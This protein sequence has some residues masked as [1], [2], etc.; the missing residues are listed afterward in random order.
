M[1]RV[2]GKTIEAFESEE[3]SLQP[4]NKEHAISTAPT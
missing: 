4:N 3:M 2:N 1:Q